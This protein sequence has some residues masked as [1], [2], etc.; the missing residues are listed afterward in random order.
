MKVLLDTNVISELQRPRPDEQVV[1][2]LT[3]IDD[4]DLFLSVVTVGEIAQGIER[5]R[6]RDGDKAHALESWLT[7][8]R[9]RFGARIIPID[10]EIAARW[11]RLNASALQAGRKPAF[12]DHLIAATALCRDLVLATRNTRDFAHTPV[13]L[14][15]PWQE[16]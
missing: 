1:D 2:W 16:R 6:P 9:T 13:S 10:V 8:L 14:T 15:N 7:A 3:A 4:G 11:G 5:I 12:S